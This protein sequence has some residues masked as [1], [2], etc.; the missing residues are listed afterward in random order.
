MKKR[1]WM[2]GVCGAA[3]IG[4]LI[5]G[6]GTALAGTIPTGFQVGGFDLSGMTR[7]EADQTIE[8]SIGEKVMRFR[9][10]RRSWDF[11]GSTRTRLMRKWRNF[12]AEIFCAGI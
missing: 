4:L 9:R 10:R 11:P 7:E 5:V 2:A 8:K 6:T 1:N 12:P 3:V